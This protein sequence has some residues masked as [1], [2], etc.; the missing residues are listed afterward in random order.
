MSNE[1]KKIA[2]LSAEDR[3]KLKEYWKELWGKEFADALVTDFKPQG[4]QKKVKAGIEEVSIK[5]AQLEQQIDP[6]EQAAENDYQGKK[7]ALL[8][9]IEQK[10]QEFIGSLGSNYQNLR[11]VK[12]FA[13]TEDSAQA[14]FGDKLANDLK[15]MI[16]Q[17][18][19]NV[20]NQTL[21]K[22][23]TSVDGI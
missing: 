7:R 12:E 18:I 14:A 19:T 17:M 4:D 9:D 5:T 21:Q 11:D 23:R 15:P 16:D 6:E 2:D 13:V 3:G 20:S 1:F 22:N 10:L 8:I